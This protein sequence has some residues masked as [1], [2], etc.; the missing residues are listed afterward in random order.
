MHSPKTQ[1]LIPRIGNPQW[2]KTKLNTTV[3]KTQGKQQPQN[4]TVR[5]ALTTWENDP[6]TLCVRKNLH[7]TAKCM[8]N[9]YPLSL[10]EDEQTTVGKWLTTNWA[11]RPTKNVEKT[12]T[13]SNPSS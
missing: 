4:M 13:G 9:T 3:N 12:K 2:L 1:K 7:P 6:N 8:G 10:R 11:L 5:T